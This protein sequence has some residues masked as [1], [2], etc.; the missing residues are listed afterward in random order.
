MNRTDYAAD[1]ARNAAL[2]RQLDCPTHALTNQTISVAEMKHW[3]A[4]AAEL[5]I[6]ADCKRYLEKQIEIR[7]AR[8]DAAREDEA[9]GGW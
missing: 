1:I 6:C 3:V 5:H 4:S 9:Q 7:D 2:H 8:H